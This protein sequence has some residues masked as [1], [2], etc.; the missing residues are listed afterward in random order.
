[1]KRSWWT[2]SQSLGQKRSFHFPGIIIGEY[3]LYFWHSLLHSTYDNFPPYDP[4]RLWVPWR[5]IPFHS[6]PHV[7]PYSAKQCQVEGTQYILLKREI[8]KGFVF[9]VVRVSRIFSELFWM[10]LAWLKKNYLKE[11]SQVICFDSFG[12]CCSEQQTFLLLSDSGK[13]PHIKFYFQIAC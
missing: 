13:K 9:V 1:M 8:F 3:V 5:Q 10:A 2:F 4:R 12:F 6:F 7:L 11:N